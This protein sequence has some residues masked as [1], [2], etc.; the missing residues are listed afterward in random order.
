[1]SIV[2]RKNIVEMLVITISQVLKY[3]HELVG[4]VCVLLSKIMVLYFKYSFVTLCLRFSII[5]SFD[6]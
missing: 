1:M 5:F 2:E 6:I 4:V 3:W